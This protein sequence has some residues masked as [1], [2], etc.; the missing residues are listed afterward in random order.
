MSVLAFDTC[1]GQVSVAVRH[2]AANGAWAT[3]A[4]AETLTTGHAERLL[5]MID[6]A[7]TAAGVGFEDLSRIAVSTGPGTFTGVRTGI[8]AARALALATGKPVVGTS[9]LALMAHAARAILDDRHHGKAQ[10]QAMAIAVDARR[11]EI[12]LQHFG[13]NGDPLGEPQ[14]SSLPDALDRLL[15]TGCALVAGSGGPLLAELAVARGRAIEPVLA[16]LEPDARSLAELADTLPLL[17]P[18]K[19]MYL[20]APDAKPQTA[21][22]L[23]RA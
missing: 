10:I 2:R 17:D 15:A 6:A 19:P 16:K 13:A 18:D 7:M 3:H 4:L 23:P 5:P 14:M 8:A 20:R 11:G 22:S 9:S 21:K 12:Y 1:M